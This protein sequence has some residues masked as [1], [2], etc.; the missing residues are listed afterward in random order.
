MEIGF[1][2]AAIIIALLLVMLGGAIVLYV[3]C[4]VFGVGIW[5]WWNALLTG[6]MLL[7]IGVIVGASKVEVS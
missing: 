2:V 3:A 4:T 6:V 5:S 7:T 1:I